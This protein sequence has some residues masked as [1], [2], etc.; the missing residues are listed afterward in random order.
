MG[1]GIAAAIPIIWKPY[2][3]GGVEIKNPLAGAVKF[4]IFG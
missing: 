4:G 1:T 3:R 2:E